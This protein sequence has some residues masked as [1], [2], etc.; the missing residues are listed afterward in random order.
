MTAKSHVPV[1]VSWIDSVQSLGCGELH[2]PSDMTCV[3][4]GFLVSKTKDRI[5]L[6]MNWDGAEFGQYMEI[7]RVAVKKLRRLK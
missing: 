1:I 4:S 6:A 2:S 5:T 3:S 7:P